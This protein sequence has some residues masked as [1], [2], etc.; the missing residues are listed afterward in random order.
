[1][2]VPN[3]CN[4]HFSGRVVSNAYEAEHGNGISVT[5]KSCNGS[6]NVYVF[7]GATTGANFR[8]TITGAWA[9]TLG[10]TVQT[11]T[12]KNDGNTVCT[13][14]TSTAVGGMVGPNAALAY[15]AINL[16]ASVAIVSGNSLPGKTDTSIV[17]VTYKTDED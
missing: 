16:A 8:G 9:T 1:M 15:T 17:F 13:F 14:T 6:T 12:L 11:V 2:A 5:V 10:S 4:P 7:G 3:A